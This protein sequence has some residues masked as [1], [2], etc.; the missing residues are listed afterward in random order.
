ML[1]TSLSLKRAHY[2]RTLLYIDIFGIYIDKPKKQPFHLNVF[3]FVK[4]LMPYV[5]TTYMTY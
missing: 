5:K 2:N 3:A 4:C 1:K